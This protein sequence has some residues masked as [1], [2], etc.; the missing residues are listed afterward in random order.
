MRDW[1]KSTE[2]LNSEKRNRV[3]LNLSIVVLFTLMVLITATETIRFIDAMAKVDNATAVVAQIQIQEDSLFAL[4]ALTN[5]GLVIK[6]FMDALNAGDLFVSDSVRARL[7]SARELLLSEGMLGFP[8]DI[9]VDLWRLLGVYTSFELD[10]Y[11]RNAGAGVQPNLVPLN[12]QVD[13]QTLIRDL[14]NLRAQQK[15]W[16][17]DLAAQALGSRHLNQTQSYLVIFLILLGFIPLFGGIVTSRHFAKEHQQLLNTREYFNRLISSLPGLVLLTTRTGEIIGA[18]KAVSTFLGHSPEWY[19]QAAIEQIL[20]KRFQQQYQLYSQNHLETKCGTVKGRE[21]LLLS[22]DGKELPVELFFGDFETA[23]GDVL[24]VSFRDVRE[25][26]ALYQRYQRVQRRFDMAM[27]ASRDGLW[28]WDLSTNEVLFSASWLEMMGILG[29]HPLNGLVVFEDCVFP[30]DRPRVKRQLEAFLRG[31]D[32]L[33][34]AEHRLRCRDGSVRDVVS[35][36]CAQR[37]GNGKVLRMVGVHSDVTSFKEVERE[38]LR[39]NRN[40][41]DRVRLRT[42]QLENALVSAEAANSAKA[43]FLAVM[44]HEIRTPMN[45]VIGMTD[46]LAKTTL[47]REQKMMVDTVRRSSQSLLS[48]LDHILDYVALESES[49]EIS[50]AELQLVEFVEGLVDSV[51]LQVAKNKQ[52]FILH[53]EPDLPA[54]VTADAAYLRKVLCN[55]ID[56]AIKFSVYTAPHGIIQLRLG[57]AE[58]QSGVALGQRRLEIKVIDNG[59]GISSEQRSQLFEPFV[60][61]ETSRARRFGGT[62]LGLAISAR[63]VK[64]MGGQ[65]ALSSAPGGDTCF[66]VELVVGVPEA[67]GVIEEPRRVAVLACIPDVLLRNAVDVMLTVNGYEVHWFESLAELGAKVDGLTLPGVVLALANNQSVRDYCVS[68]NLKMLALS[69]RPRDKAALSVDRVY[70][71]PL[72]PSALLRALEREQRGLNSL[73]SGA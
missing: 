63:I 12:P 27:T 30:E 71:D 41:E 40:L 57:L 20:P 34:R 50:P 58:D 18:S 6:E 3:I 60:Q 52:R 13:T 2:R 62:G 10:G 9:R 61:M 25:Q 16:V 68:H 70:T 1:V 45:G 53:I 33:F 36:A 49:A 46:L 35:R 44:G 8:K 51:G 32:V 4:D 66:A 29:G 72:L 5:R 55:L 54:I 65:I 64:L 38:V 24:V 56:N 59:I 73:I 15:K 39:L 23:D 37:D 7:I 43:A 48:T 42:Q 21:L 28:D 26:R 19:Q 14:Q 17:S 69:E 67:Q 31:K 11:S 22:A 47:D